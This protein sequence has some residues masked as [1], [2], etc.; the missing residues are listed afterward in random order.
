MTTLLAFRALRDNLIWALVA[1]DGRALLVDP[2]AAEAVQAARRQG[3]DVRDILLTHHHADHIGAAEELAADC[4]ARLHGPED[5]RIPFALHHCRQGD[6]FEAA[7]FEVQVLAVPGHTHSHLAF[8]VAGHL[9]CGDT[10]F[11]L[12]CGRLFEGE[13]WQMLDSLGRLAALPATTLVCCGHEYTLANGAFAKVV[14]AHNPAREDWLVEAQRR[15]ASGQPS[16]PSRLA[17]ECAAN[18]FLRIDTPGVRAGLAARGADHPDPVQRFA[19]LRQWKDG[20]C[21]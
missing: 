5:P 3:L 14:E 13:A 16:L 12:G 17:I 4:A 2:G 11:S 6:R 18:P 7:G 10:L 9:F 20:F 1:G 19:A 8:V 21:G 15:I